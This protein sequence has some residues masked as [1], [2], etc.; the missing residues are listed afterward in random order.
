MG[1]EPMN[2]GFAD[3]RLTTWPRRHVNERLNNTAN[4]AMCEGHTIPNMTVDRDISAAPVVAAIVLTYN[5]EQHIEACLRTLTWADEVIVFDSLSTDQTVAIALQAGARVI[6]CPFKNFAQQRNAALDAAKTDWV[7]FVDA[8]ERC[9]DDL[10]LEIRGVIQN[11]DH[12]VWATPRDNY[13]FGVLT[14]GAGWYPDYQARLFKVGRASFDPAREVHEVA[15]FE[16]SM[17]HLIHTLT[18]YNYDTVAQFHEKQRRYSQLEAGI[19]FKQGTQPKLRNFLLQPL[20][21]FRRR[22]VTLKGYQDGWHGLR[23]CLLMAYYNF[24]MYRRL[25]HLW[26][27]ARPS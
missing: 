1:I 5:E 18:H 7:F 24:D 26:T 3:P 16:G 13:L 25:S 11:D 14:R 23:L 8:D 9:T 12:F 17:G 15:I 6:Q 20:R 22:F 2:K 4:Y 21:E 27:L 19:L 10:A